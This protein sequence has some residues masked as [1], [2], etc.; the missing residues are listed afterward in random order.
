[1]RLVWSRKKGTE[2]GLSSCSSRLPPPA[3]AATRVARLWRRPQ[4]A[5]FTGRHYRHEL[6]FGGAAMGTAHTG[7]FVKHFFPALGISGV[8]KEAKIPEKFV[9]ICMIDA[10]LFKISFEQWR[11][12]CL[13]EQA[14][15]DFWFFFN[16]VEYHSYI[17]KFLMRFCFF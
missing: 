10:L 5:S 11:G 3:W 12:N 13:K 1:M 8:L 4:Q 14:F 2:Y 9:C 16:L 17:F 15:G 7:S 6:L